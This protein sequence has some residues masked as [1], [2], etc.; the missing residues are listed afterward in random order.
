LVNRS[1]SG[2]VVSFVVK[3]ANLANGYYTIIYNQNNV[4]PVTLESFTAAKMSTDAAMVKWTVGADYG[5]G[6]F[7]IER[8]SDGIQFS[9]I[10][11]VDA[12][13]N[14]AASESYSFVDN[15]PLSGLS[16][17][18]IGMTNSVGEVAY[19]SVVPVDFSATSRPVTLYPVPAT[20]ILHVSAPG[21]SGGGTIEL[22]SV[23]G[24]LLA[25]YQV[26]ML[27]GAS[28]PVNSLPTGAYFVRIR[29]GAQAMALSFVKR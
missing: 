1:I 2:N 29:A 16:Y 25:N 5:S 11:T 4:L 6:F 9:T 28:L 8:S 3:A 20:D 17:Y 27:D 10:G 21:V 19:S 23:A 13:A 26:T 22:F 24:Q 15:S 14:E 12:I 7:S 18:R